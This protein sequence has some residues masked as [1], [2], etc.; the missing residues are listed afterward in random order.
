MTMS[1]RRFMLLAVAVVALNSFFWLAQG[2]FALPRALIADLF[3]PRMIRAEVVDLAPDGSTQDQF[4]D[5]GI[6]R[7][8]TQSSIMVFEL[9]GN[10]ATI[11]ISSSTT[12]SGRVF[13]VSRLRRGMRVLVVR[14]ANGSATQIQVGG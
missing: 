9:D 8:V 10:T 13:S 2:G 3:G 1:R 12:V 5:R 14:P 4:V 7:A 6:I 11:P